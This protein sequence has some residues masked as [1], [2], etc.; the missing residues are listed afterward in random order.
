[1]KV[2]RLVSDAKLPSKAH[3]NDAGWD[4]YA[5]EDVDLSYNNLTKVRTGI[6][7]GFEEGTFG[8]L[9]DRSSMAAKG[10]IVSGGVI[11]TN[12]TGEIT[13]MLTL[14]GYVEPVRIRKGD[15]IAQ[16]LILPLIATELSCVDELESTDR[17]TKGFG[18]SGQ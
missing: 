5:A 3:P 18:S 9:R 8:L 14:T 4:L 1:M 11:D 15:K 16:M 10:I 13:V 12:Y 7:F 17:G 2:K 6:A